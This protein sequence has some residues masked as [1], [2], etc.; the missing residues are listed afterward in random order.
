MLGHIAIAALGGFYAQDE[1]SGA[2]LD[3]YIPAAHIHVSGA[4][5]WSKS[6][7]AKDAVFERLF[8]DTQIYTKLQFLMPSSVITYPTGAAIGTEQR[9]A[10]PRTWWYGGCSVKNFCLFT[11][12][13]ANLLEPYSPTAGV[14]TVWTKCGQRSASIT[15]GHTSA[16]TT[17]VVSYSS[18]RALPSV[19]RLGDAHTYTEQEFYIGCLTND[20]YDVHYL[21]SPMQ[22]LTRAQTALFEHF[23]STLR[24]L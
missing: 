7:S 18:L 22:S 2:V 13:N 24:E 10:G 1:E 6:I 14:M 12:E 16:L 19:L 3:T 15:V 17:T 21:V 9:S 5:T 11:N 20:Y 4:H 23:N 8:D